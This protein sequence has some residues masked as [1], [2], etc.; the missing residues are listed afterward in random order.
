MSLG[1]NICVTLLVRYTM[2][3]YN[4][5]TIVTWLLSLLEGRCLCGRTECGSPCQKKAGGGC[6]QYMHMI[7]FKNSMVCV[8]H[9][10]KHYHDRQ[11]DSDN[12][13]LQDA[14]VVRAHSTGQSRGPCRSAR[15]GLLRLIQITVAVGERGARCQASR[16]S[17]ALASTGALVN[18]LWTTT[19]LR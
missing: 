11:V 8:S 17:I 1:T 15:R 19:T 10:R 14:L 5:V 9:R 13:L 12:I 7:Y 2:S 18:A 3:P 4:K 16:P 6:L